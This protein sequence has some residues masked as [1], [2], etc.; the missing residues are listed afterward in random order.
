[1]RSHGSR[2]PRMARSK[3][4]SGALSPSLALKCNQFS[5]HT[6]TITH[7]HPT[8]GKRSS[9]NFA[10]KTRLKMCHMAYILSDCLDYS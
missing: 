1:M 6:G 5:V 8:S 3:C 9:A 4:T 2:Y 10:K 7:V